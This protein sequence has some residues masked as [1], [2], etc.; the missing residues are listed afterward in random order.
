MFLGAFL[1][2]LGG[3]H[4]T[5]FIVTQFVLRTDKKDKAGRCPVHLMVMAFAYRA[6]GS[7]ASPTSRA[8]VA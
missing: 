1:S 7:D 5:P 2:T 3:N 4:A 6:D 8:Q